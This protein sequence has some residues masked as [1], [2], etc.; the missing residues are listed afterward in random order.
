MKKDSAVYKTRKSGSNLQMILKGKKGSKK[1]IPSKKSKPNDE[2]ISDNKA[3]FR[4][5]VFNGN[6]ITPQLKK[7]YSGD[8]ADILE[9]DDEEDDNNSYSRGG[10][11]L[12]SITVIISPVVETVATLSFL[13]ISYLLH[14]WKSLYCQ[15]FGRENRIVSYC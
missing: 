13:L 15:H 10:C 8:P 12:L 3:G 14:S 9:G 5:Q 6:L 11:L 1:L 2:K 4:S 7:I